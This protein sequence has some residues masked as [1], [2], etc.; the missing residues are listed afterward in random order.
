M[1]CRGVAVGGCACCGGGSGGGDGRGCKENV[2]CGDGG[3]N[4]GGGKAVKVEDEF[5]AVGAGVV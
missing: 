1:F 4:H 5:F 3:L 2:G